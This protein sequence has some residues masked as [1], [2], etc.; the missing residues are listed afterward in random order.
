M[1]A[2]FGFTPSRMAICRHASITLESATPLGQ[3]VAQVSQ[4]AQSH[5]AEL[6]STSSRIPIW[7]M[8]IT[9]FGVMSIAYAAGHPAVHSPHW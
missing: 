5:I 3:R 2:S 1:L 6:P 8:R 7:A 4:P 9:W